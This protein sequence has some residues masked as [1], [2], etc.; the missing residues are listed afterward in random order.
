MKKNICMTGLS[1]SRL[2]RKSHGRIAFRGMIDTL[3]AEVLEAQVL[4]LREG[5]AWY[6]A[7]LG[8]VLEA[9]RKILAAEV[10]EEPL[11]P[12][13]LFGLS[14]DEIHRQSH[15]TGGAFG[16]PHPLP[17]CSMGALAVRL[18]TLR[19][20]IREGELLA[21]RVLRRRGDIITAMNRLSSALYW[22]F[23]K[24]ISEPGK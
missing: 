9:L 7:S 17:G 24:C 4:A 10:K 20:R 6:C 22:L 15:D 18:N 5:A 8:E 21:V 2:V 14:L 12:F 1:G 3:E 19:A 16:F 23:C 13:G 11:P